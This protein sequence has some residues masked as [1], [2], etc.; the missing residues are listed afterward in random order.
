M[1]FGITKL[2]SKGQIVIPKNLRKKMGVGEEFLVV[3]EKDQLLLKSLKGLSEKIKDDLRF[4]AKTEEAYQRIEAGEVIVRSKE[5][6]LKEL[7]PL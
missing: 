2:S 4:A 1:D 3:R 7:R 6:F 5:D